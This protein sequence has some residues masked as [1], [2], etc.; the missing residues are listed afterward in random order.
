VVLFPL[1]PLKIREQRSSILGFLVSRVRGA[2]GGISSI[3]HILA[4]FSEQ[5]LGY[6]VSMRCSYYPQCL[7]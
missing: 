2:L 7:V 3:P 6:G 5:N 1:F 4:S